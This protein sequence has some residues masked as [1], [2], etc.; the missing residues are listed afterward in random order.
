M[1]MPA[2]NVGSY[3]RVSPLDAVFTFGKHNGTSIREVPID[4]LRWCL[5]EITDGPE[6]FPQLIRAELHRRQHEGVTTFDFEEEVF[7]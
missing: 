4:Y 2:Y 3:M 7:P 6:E 5:R 1:S